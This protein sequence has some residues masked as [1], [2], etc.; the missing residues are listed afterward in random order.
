MSLN[1]EKPVWVL[2]DGRAGHWRQASA[3]ASYLPATA[4]ELPFH[5]RTPWRVFA[6]HSLPL[7]L[8]M[9]PALRA[10]LTGTAP[11]A[12]I[13]C[14]RQSA[15]VA[16]WLQRQLGQQIHTVQILNCGLRPERFS[17]VIAPAH[18]K[19]VG[20]NVIQS[21]GSLNPVDE[22]WLKRAVDDSEGIERL[23][24]PR[25]T[26]LLG[27]P[28][29][30]FDFS[31]SWFSSRLAGLTSWVSSQ[32]GSLILVA[33]PR[34]PAWVPDALQAENSDVPQV[35][36]PWR[37]QENAASEAQYAS[38]IAHADCLIVT[39]DS[40]NMVSEACASGKPVLLMGWRRVSGR[41]ARFC[42]R[43]MEDDFARALDKTGLGVIPT[44]VCLRET[45]KIARQLTASGLLA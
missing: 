22:A 41:I 25:I 32:Q 9:H 29:R 35:W 12:I 23:P 34:T 28:S 6:P 42:E 30:H 27:G 19:L 3:L 8:A 18:D 38:T 44:T 11:S 7:G 14:G 24:Q 21:L 17:W 36:I 37:Q 4:Q 5:L 20:S 13:S 39:A 1:S 40:V 45:E 26:V 10:A 16:R 33:S 31:R 43:M 15:L 2:N